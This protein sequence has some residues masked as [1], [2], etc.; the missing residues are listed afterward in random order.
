MVWVW[1]SRII[2]LLFGVF[3]GM[4]ITVKYYEEGK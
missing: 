4:L 2:C 3:I 1:V